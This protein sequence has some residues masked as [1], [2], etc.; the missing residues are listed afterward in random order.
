[1][2]LKFNLKFILQVKFEILIFK[3]FKRRI[4]LGVEGSMNLE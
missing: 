1:M 3:K 4:N 2:I